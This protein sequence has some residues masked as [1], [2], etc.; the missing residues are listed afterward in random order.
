[1]LSTGENYQGAKGPAVT[2]AELAKEQQGTHRRSA[3]DKEYLD[4]TDSLL[5]REAKEF[6]LKGIRADFTHF[7][8]PANPLGL[9]RLAQIYREDDKY[10]GSKDNF[11]VKW[12]VFLKYCAEAQL[13]VADLSDAFH[14]MLKGGARDLAFAHPELA[15]MAVD[16]QAALIADHFDDPT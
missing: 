12:R 5:F 9:Q 13:D 10:G 16:N 2:P 11:R 7:V 3:F 6:S 1:M 4:E 15:N 8:A 14:H